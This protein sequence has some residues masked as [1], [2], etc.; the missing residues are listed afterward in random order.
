MRIAPVVACLLSCLVLPVSPGHAE[1]MVGGY[2]VNDPGNHPLSQFGNSAQGNMPP[3]RQIAG[4]ATQLREP[5]YG[6]YEPSQQLIYISD[7]RGQAIRVFPAFASGDVAPL[8]TINPPLLGQPRGNVPILAHGE[9]GAIG[10]GCCIQTYPLNASGDAVT[11]IRRLSWGGNSPTELNNPASLIYLPATDEY[12]V[13]DSALASPFARHI[14]FFPRTANG[15]VAPSR[16]ITGANVAGA[17]SMAYDP[18]GHRIFVLRNGQT[19]GSVTYG[20]IDVF[21]DSASGDAVPVKTIQGVSTQLQITPPDYFVGIGYDLYRNTVMVSSTREGSPARN[22]IVTLDAGGNG[23]L[24]P[25]QILEGTTLSPRT[26]GTPFGITSIVPPAPPLLA[27]ATPTHLAYGQTSALSSYGGSGGGA[28][29]FAVTAGPGICSI[30]NTTL[31]ATGVGTCTVTATQAGNPQTASVDL[32]IAQAT[33][34]PLAAFATPNQLL[35]G[36]N[37][38]LS[39]QGGSGTGAVWFQVDSGFEFCTVQGDELVAVAPGV[40]TVRAYKGADAN[41]YV[42]SSPTVS[43]T[44]NASMEMF[45]DGF[46]TP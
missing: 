33:Q 24:S 40:C 23:D 1:I 42:T 8:R 30:Q 43:V 7:F 3:N 9:L 32:A 36:Q 46:E 17:V 11:A 37:S 13:L 38:A 12:A 45:A 39:V 26:V 6:S 18:A 16:R 2:L 22:R 10:G 4:P 27:I 25:N 21:N 31:T 35:V 28:V 34:A 29:G 20:R 15:G 19:Q 44:V 14:L 5:H 41:Y